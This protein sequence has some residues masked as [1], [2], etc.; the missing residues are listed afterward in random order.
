MQT[1][2]KTVANHDETMYVGY[3]PLSHFSTA[4]PEAIYQPSNTICMFVY[5]SFFFV[6]SLSSMYQCILDLRI[7]SSCSFPCSEL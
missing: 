3:H 7:S 4:H 5:A 1:G 6:S 2:N